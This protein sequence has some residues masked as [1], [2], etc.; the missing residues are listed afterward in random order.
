LSRRIEAPA[1]WLER[2]CRIP[3]DFRGSATPVGLYRAAVPHLVDASLAPTIEI[4]VKHYLEDKPELIDRWSM[5]IEDKRWTPSWTFFGN[6]V[7][8]IP[9][10]GGREL[11]STY[12][13]PAAAY[14]AFIVRE[15]MWVLS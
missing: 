14:A 3:D 4:A 6:Q 7:L 15:A 5:W 9:E 10:G 8:W 11:I 12:E 2:L 1:D 13:S